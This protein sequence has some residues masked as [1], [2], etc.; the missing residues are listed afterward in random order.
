M[1]AGRVMPAHM[2]RRVPG[3]GV[4]YAGEDMRAGR[5]IF[6]EPQ[7]RV[8]GSWQTPG[9]LCRAAMARFGQLADA[10]SSL[11]SRNGAFWAVGRH[12]VVFADLQ[13]PHTTT[14]SI[15]STL[16]RPQPHT[17]GAAKL[18]YTGR[19]TCEIRT[20]LR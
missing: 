15:S 8:W 6:A 1:L 16:V 17:S 13:R 19:E 3:R 12:R 7:W 5:V 14:C 4:V 2:Q 10:G 18:F 9:H 20:L 11:Q